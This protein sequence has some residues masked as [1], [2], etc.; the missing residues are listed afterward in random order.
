MLKQKLVDDQIQALRN[1][2]QENLSILRYILAQIKNKEIEKRSDLTDDETTMVL[3]K[4]SKELHESIEAAKLGKREGLVTEYQQQLQLVSSYLPKE[5]SDEQLKKEI[6]K[7]I[8]E[9]Q[10][11]SNKNP[12]AIIGISIKQLKNKADPSRIVK[13]LQSISKL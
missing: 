3:R 13:V 5:L 1:H 7:I 9:N 12:K 2:D 10:D 6:E 8:A 4:I 11:L